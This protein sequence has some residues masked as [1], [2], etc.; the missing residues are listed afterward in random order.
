[1]NEKYSCN[2]PEPQQLKT[3]GFITG[4][5][6]IN[7]T[8]AQ[9]KAL[10]HEITQNLLRNGTI[11]AEIFSRL[12]DNQC[13][14]ISS[15]TILTFVE[16]GT[17]SFDQ[18][19][20]LTKNQH[21]NLTT[22]LLQNLLQNGRVTFR[23]ILCLKLTIQQHFNL[24]TPVVR[25]LVLE[26]VLTLTQAINLTVEARTA[27]VEYEHMQTQLRRRKLTIEQIEG[28]VWS[29]PCP[30]SSVPISL[31]DRAGKAFYQESPDNHGQGE[32]LISSG[33]FALSAIDRRSPGHVDALTSTQPGK[34][35]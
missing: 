12:A 8:V 24:G 6:I 22:P 5:Q 34:R 10:E 14:N 3:E 1:M 26:G 16:N 9:R 4:I 20:C 29:E 18:A 19:L 17:L 33:L 31:F 25:D 23:E 11:T 13:E 15:S 2:F 35:G 28:M 32:L 30:D 27:L 21:A 7:L